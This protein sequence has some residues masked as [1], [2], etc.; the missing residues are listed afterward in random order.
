MIKF[1]KMKI[2]DSMV[3]SNSYLVGLSMFLLVYFIGFA[4]NWFGIN[5]V[6]VN[7]VWFLDL[8]ESNWINYLIVI[9]IVI[10]IIGAVV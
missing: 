7:S 8:L 4:S 10:P 6:I 1:P 2:F 9:I 5:E 3:K